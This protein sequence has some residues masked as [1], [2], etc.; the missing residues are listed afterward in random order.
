M[1]SPCQIAERC[2]I[3]EHNFCWTAHL[4]SCRMQPG[5]IVTQIEY[6]RTSVLCGKN[7]ME[8]VKCFRK[9]EF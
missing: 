5:G 1:I 3:N 4:L 8:I 7:M 6:H 2:I 9:Q